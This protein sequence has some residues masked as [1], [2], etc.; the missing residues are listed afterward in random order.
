[1]RGVPYHGAPQRAIESGCAAEAANAIGGGGLRR[2]DRLTIP[3]RRHGH[4]SREDAMTSETPDPAQEIDSSDIEA[5]QNDEGLIQADRVDLIT[6][7][8]EEED[9][10]PDRDPPAP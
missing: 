10:D 5:I 8:L 7:Q 6:S 2:Y 9:A 1:L 3:V 4:H